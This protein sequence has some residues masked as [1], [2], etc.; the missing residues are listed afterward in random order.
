MGPTQGAGRGKQNKGGMQ[1]RRNSA[2]IGNIGPGQQP[3]HP[4]IHVSIQSSYGSLQG[5]VGYRGT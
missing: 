2:Q 3:Q 5:R 4:Q 1:Q